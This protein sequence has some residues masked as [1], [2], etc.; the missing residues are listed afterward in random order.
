[1]IVI[2][3]VHAHFYP[4]V[5]VDKLVQL[6]GADNSTWGKGVQHL[7]NTRIKVN[8]P[9]Y[10]I[11]A[12]LAAMDEAG[13]DIEALSLGIPHCYFE[14]AKDAEEMAR[15]AND[16]LAEVCARYPQRFKAYATLPFPY[17][18]ASLR[19][20]DRAINTLGL[21]GA[22]IGANV[23]GHHLDEE[24]FVPVYAEM[25]RLKLGLFMHPMIPPAQEEMLDYNLS[26]GVGYLLDSTLAVLRMAY[27]GVF[28]E[29]PDLQFIMPHLGTILIS[30]WER[31]ASS[32]R[33]GPGAN[34]QIDRPVDEYLSRLYYDGVNFHVPAWHCA[35]ETF[36]AEQIMYGSDY[37]FGSAD[38]M[39]I[40]KDIIEGLDITPEQ[41]E[42]IYSGNALKVLR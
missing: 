2:V 42:L 26:S 8:R 40:V 12:H 34:A 1:V 13:V 39:Q 33:P 16:G 36:G 21:H 23:R 35:I 3:D 28:A 19:E 4:P 11:E 20:L 6:T 25:G 30:A 5:Y 14:G 31:V 37:P 22:T 7:L 10:D 24:S 32:L 9:M 18:D 38:R 41:R 15:I 27:R 17:T 29:N